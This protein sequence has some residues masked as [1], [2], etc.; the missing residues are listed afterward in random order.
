MKRPSTLRTA[1]WIESVTALFDS[2]S[3]SKEQFRGFQSRALCRLVQHAYDSVPYYRR[4]FDREG[5]KPGDIRG[6][7]DLGLIPVTQRDHLQSLP[8]QEVVAHGYNHRNLVVR[9]TS[10]S[11]G[12]PASIRRTQ[13]EEWLL[14][15]LRLRANTYYGGRLTSRRA[16]IQFRRGDDSCEDSA[17]PRPAY[18][19][20]GLLP[21]EVVHCLLP[22]DELISRLR[23]I[24]PDVISG[25][26]GT[27]SWIAG[28][29]NAADRACIRPR[30]VTIGGETV[31][32][33]MRRQ[34][35][36]V[37]RV[38][39]ISHYG[40]HEFN[41]IATEC[42][43][44]GQYHLCEDNVLGEVLRDG[45]PAAAG[46]EGEFVGTALHSYAMPLIRYRLGDTVIRG[47]D[48][49]PCGAS[50]STLLGIQ[51]RML[52]RFLLPNGES[53]H[54]YSLVFRLLQH[55]PWI[56]RYQITQVALDRVQV[57]LV[58][59]EEPDPDKAVRI[60]R[61]LAE[62]LGQGIHVEVTLVAEIPPGPNG[63]FRPYQSYVTSSPRAVSASPA[64]PSDGPEPA[65]S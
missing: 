60:E 65:G 34:I 63:K 36:T 44:A 11:T 13:P 38:P 49:C 43:R 40:S 47:G 26:P 56:R 14:Q 7:G 55:A 20:W 23:T 25:Y 54:P 27:I 39:A 53:I 3:W 48:C 29:M 17:P 21:A 16:L 45:R 22:P 51:G 9:R 1:G 41:L 33:E 59:L 4:L 35:E 8:A 6:I 64:R 28:H 37:F 10:G 31:T 18:M 19:K 46:D 12:A 62:G 32:P 24:S 15:A 50:C 30:Y 61:V 52:D 42:R 2:P 57:Q 58:P 5:L